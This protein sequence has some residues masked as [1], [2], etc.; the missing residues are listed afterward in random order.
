MCELRRA[1]V[2]KFAFVQND[3]FCSA[4]YLPPLSR[5]AEHD[6]EHEHEKEHGN[7]C[8]ESPDACL[9]YQ[10]GSLR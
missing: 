3:A 8:I 4:H 2:H 6:S 9:P 10:L 1:D 7:Q 5:G